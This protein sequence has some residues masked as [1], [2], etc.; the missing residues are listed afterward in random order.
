[1]KYIKQIENYN[2][3]KFDYRKSDIEKILNDRGVEFDYIEYL[4]S[5]TYGDVY[6]ISKN[7]CLK[8]TLSK[9]D[10]YYA[11]II[12]S[13]NSEYI[14]SIKDVFF[15]SYFDIGYNIKNGFIIMELLNTTNTIFNRFVDYLHYQN[16]LS[17]KYKT[18]N[19]EDVIKYFKDKMV[20]LSESQIIELWDLYSTLRDELK[21]YN[22]PIDDLRGRNIGYKNTKPVAF[23]IADIYTS[24]Q[25]DYDNI[26]EIKT[27]IK[28]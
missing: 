8:I 11:D 3:P 18:V 13:I 27:K 14:I 10:V 16:P 24:K 15:H 23:D 19:K 9:S 26:D 4:D 17:K 28:L 6:R 25:I 2:S 1:M 20:G 7:I 21:K 12:K 5:G 22:L